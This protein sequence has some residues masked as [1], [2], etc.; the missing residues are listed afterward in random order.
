MEKVIIDHWRKNPIRDIDVYA[1]MYKNFDILN[2]KN[3][4]AMAV[5]FFGSKMS[6]ETL[7]VRI[8]KLADAYSK[9][10]VKAGDAIGILTV[11]MPLVQENMMASSY[12]GTTAVWLD[13]REKRDTLID[14]INLSGIK[15]LVIFDQVTPLI[16]SLIAETDVET[17]FV[18]SPFDFFN[19]IKK[20]LAILK[21][22][23]EGKKQIEIPDDKRFMRYENFL[24]SGNAKTDLKPAAFEKDR[25]SIIAQS[26]GSTGVS[27]SIQHTEFNFNHAVW[28]EAHL[29]LPL[30]ARKKML[31]TVPPFIIYGNNNSTY[32]ALALGMEAVL[33]P[34]VEDNVVF[35]NLGKFDVAFGVPLHYR[36]IYTKLVEYEEKIK[37]LE[38]D[39]SASA[40]RELSKVMKEYERI[41]KAIHG[42]VMVSGGDKI[43]AQEIIDLQMKLGVPIVNGYGNN[44]VAGASVVSPIYG[45]KPGSI[46]V[47]MKG[48]EVAAFDSSGNKLAREEEGEIRTKT[49]HAFVGYMNNEAETK[50]IKKT[51]TEGNLWVC[52][53]DSGYVDE[54]GFVFATGR[55]ERLIKRAA[56]KISPSTI[57]NVIVNLPYVQNCCVVGVPDKDEAEVP[58]VY[59]ELTPEYKDS[60]AE[61]IDKINDECLMR[62]PDYECPKYIEAVD[63]MP[64][65]NGKIAWKLLE[66]QGAEYVVLLDKGNVLKK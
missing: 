7:K 34:F 27:K 46:G 66:K 61:C 10:G 54:D 48:V 58:M 1:T 9:S 39:N 57:E 53:G 50:R 33:S 49:P 42:R 29:D 23:K 36:Y 16:E 18:A 12:L 44:E 4:D 41:L 55:I 37:E 8:K 59:V 11:N 45:A 24:Q 38:K 25:I 32:A 3:M 17:V 19:P 30:Y 52:T 6:Y 15:K 40:K 35:D 47:P 21:D 2:E 65:K 43:G 31:I 51:D 22:K 63:K 62:L 60:F 13:L 26:S 14:K 56:F 5:N 64:S 20:R 28:G